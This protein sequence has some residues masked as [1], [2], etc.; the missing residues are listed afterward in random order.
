V[1]RPQAGFQSAE[2]EG[3]TERQDTPRVS[4]VQSFEAVLFGCFF[5]FLVLTHFRGKMLQ[6][7]GLNRSLLS[8]QLATGAALPSPRRH[9]L[10]Q[11]RHQE[12]G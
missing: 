6:G 9:Q 7:Q 11:F 2:K 3:G 1:G 12:Q 8:V 5:M 10:Y 4:V